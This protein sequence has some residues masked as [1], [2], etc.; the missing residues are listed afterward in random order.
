M[1]SVAVSLGGS[2]LVQEEGVDIA[3]TR[4]IAEV[5]ERV[6]KTRKVYAVVGGGITARRYIQ[7]ARRLGADESALDE[8]GIAVTR[9]NARVLIAALRSPYPV[10]AKTFDEAL[11]AGK[12]YG[13]V[14]LGGTHPGHT[15]DA[16]A[17]MM[18]ERAKA[19]RLVIATNVDGVY[20]ADPKKDP[21]AKILPELSARDLVNITIGS[22]NRAGSAGVVDSLGAKLILRSG[23]ETAVV[24][25]RDL[26]SLE[27]ALLSQPFTG[28]VVKPAEKGGA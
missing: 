22:E 8:L 17:V 10:P 28:S 1:E 12:G 4:E 27:A 19:K 9:I 14:V 11:L 20:T 7:G 21:N 6:A 24:D 23:I 5:L 16:V 26:K 25:G 13:I 18:A 3:L 2:F 15:T